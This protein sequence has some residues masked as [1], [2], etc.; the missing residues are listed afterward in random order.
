[1]LTAVI[2]AALCSAPAPASEI[3]ESPATGTR[4]AGLLSAGLIAEGID[5]PL[6]LEA[7]RLRV[8]HVVWAAF[9]APGQSATSGAGLTAVVSVRVAAA[10]PERAALTIIVSDGRAFDRS[11]DLSGI[12]P[13][14]GPRMIATNIANIVTGI[15]AGTVEAD[16]D[17]VPLP[18]AA[19]ECPACPPVKT[20]PLCPEPAPRTAKAN[21]EAQPATHA[22]GISAGLPLV[23]GIAAPSDADRF[24]AFG[25]ELGISA[26]LRRGAT[27][28]VGYRLAG[29]RNTAEVGVLRNRV[30]LGAGYTLRRGAFELTTM[31]MGTIEPWMVRMQGERA[32]FA[33]I[34]REQALIGLSAHVAPGIRWPMRDRRR[35]IVL[36]P[37]VELAASASPT[38]D[39]SIPQIAL[40]G[41]EASRIRVGGVELVTGLATRVWID[42]RRDGPS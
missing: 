11:I 34:G 7:I 42:L 4:V 6:L 19:Q 18:I 23:V 40:P 10:E 13:G 37:F 30:L 24:A 33:N 1:M 22:I 2:V 25:I 26:R 21:R 31:L 3:E 16:R 36:T 17:A 9:V 20:A 15:E 29:R 28:G 39:F 32:T 41:D 27:F 35:S 38:D 14:Q 8:P 12:E 5:E